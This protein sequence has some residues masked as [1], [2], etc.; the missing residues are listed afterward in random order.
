MLVHIKDILQ[1]AVR[2]GYAVGA[3]NTVNFEVTLAIMRAAVSQR[4]PVIIQISEKTIRYAELKPIADVIRTVARHIGG[5]VPVA[6]HFAHGRSFQTVRE[7][8]DAGF[9]SVHIDASEQSLEENIA[10][11]RQA[12]GYAHRAGVWVQGELGMILG[13]EGLTRRRGKLTVRAC[14]TDPARV[15]EYLRATAVDTLAVSIGTL[16]GAFRG[17]ERL[18]L[19]RLSAIAKV[20]RLPLVLHGGSGVAPVQIQSAIRRGIRIVNV[21][22]ELRIAFTH[23]LRR[24]LRSQ[25]GQYDLRAYLGPAALA[26][27]R[28]VEG[29]LKLFGSAGRV[30]VAA[31]ERVPAGKRRGLVRGGDPLIW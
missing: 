5:V 23:S 31:G 19:P 24:T 8:V 15:A 16:H 17:R 4:A 30:K 29:K 18:D 12:V 11:T 1:D 21:D 26:L 10:V 14:L 7:C 27:E 3:F 28:V 9:S 22:T 6:L 25:P 2:R 20:A 13:Q